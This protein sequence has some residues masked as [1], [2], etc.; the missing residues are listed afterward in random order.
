MY[1]LLDVD[2]TLTFSF[3]H[4]PLDLSKINNKLIQF[5][6]DQ[7]WYNLTLCTDMLLNQDC[8]QHRIQLI[9]WL[10]QEGFTVHQ[11]LTPSDLLWNQDEFWA[12]SE[13]D[14]LL[15][16]SLGKGHSITQV[17]TYLL[18]K[19]SNNQPGSAFQ[20]AKQALETQGDVPE[21]LVN[22]SWLL[23]RYLLPV[24]AQ[25]MKYSHIKALMLEFFLHHLAPDIN[26]IV[27]IDDHRLVIQSVREV[28]EKR[29]H[30]GLL[31]PR[32]DLIQV[33]STGDWCTYNSQSSLSDEYAINNSTR[34]DI[35]A[36]KSKI[37]ALRQPPYSRAARYQA[38]SISQCVREELRLGCVDLNQAPSIQQACQEVFFKNPVSMGGQ[39]QNT[40]RQRLK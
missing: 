20:E 37:A 5:L 36:I 10:E 12:Y 39:K 14:D 6:K 29:S 35:H 30:R 24:L 15:T 38:R 13:P 19:A 33:L 25:R 9:S 28:L 22:H 40:Y 34:P 27:L 31:T 17:E 8:L 16:N 21:E 26:E 7:K 3:E 11:V 18:E 2:K 32:I 4:S 23:A 1:V